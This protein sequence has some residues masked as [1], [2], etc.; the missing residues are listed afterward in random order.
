MYDLH[1]NS[2]HLR[3]AHIGPREIYSY[4]LKQCHGTNSAY[5]ENGFWVSPGHLPSRKVHSK[6]EPHDVHMVMCMSKCCCLYSNSYCVYT[7][8]YVAQVFL[9]SI[10]IHPHLHFRVP[11]KIP[12]TLSEHCIHSTR[13]KNTLIE[14]LKTSTDPQI[15]KGV[16]APNNC[17]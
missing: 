15:S 5:F 13:F 14:L 1:S 12:V 11:M 17:F 2:S 6:S 3:C 4:D 16:D 7:S 9:I 8:L 10:H